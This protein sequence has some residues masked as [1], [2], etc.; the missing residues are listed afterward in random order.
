MVWDVV[1]RNCLWVR[2]ADAGTYLHSQLSNDIAALSPG[3]S[4]QSFVLEPTGKINAVLRVTRLT[5]ITPTDSEVSDDADLEPETYLLDTDATGDDFSQMVRRLERFKIRVKA[6]FS[7]GEITTIVWRVIDV[8]D[9]SPLPQQSSPLTGELLQKMID[10]LEWPAPNASVPQD[11][12]LGVMN[13]YVVVASWWADQR[14]FDVLVIPPVQDEQ[15][16]PNEQ[17]TSVLMMK[18]VE[19][20]RLASLDS[21]RAEIGEI[22]QLRV[23]SGWPAMGTEIRPGETIPA[24]TGIVQRVA[25]FTKGCYPGQE[26]V[27]RMDS[28]GSTAPQSLRVVSLD[29]LG[30]LGPGDVITVNGADVGRV[31]SVAGGVA[32]AYV[33]RSVE[34]GV[35]VGRP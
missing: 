10:E 9:G 3:E 20:L 26:L 17:S 1:R 30:S 32:L 4:C 31:T 8:I 24:A 5:R 13:R 28:R 2:G 27:E 21:R 23:S 16:P 33:S 19:G 12:N 22:E 7:V 11:T 18:V 29:E 6:D 14:A 25:S 15:E 34:L 35:V